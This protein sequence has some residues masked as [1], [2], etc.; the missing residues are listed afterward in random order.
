MTWWYWM[1]LGLALLGMEL[2]TPGGFYIL[3]FGLS[4]LVVGAVAGLAPGVSDWVQWLLFSVLSIASLVLFRNPLLAKIKSVDGSKP[5]VDSLVGE[6]A[7]LTE[8]LVPGATGKVEFR[9]AAWTARNGGHVTLHRGQ[10]C[11]VE[12]VEGLTL[13]IT[14]E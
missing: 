4:A 8:D 5:D 10:R 7:T 3:F 11:R 1:L 13:W 12:R 6:L 14:A 2:L 9:G